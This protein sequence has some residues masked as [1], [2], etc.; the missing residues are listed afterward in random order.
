VSEVTETEAEK[1]IRDTFDQ[2]R[3]WHRTRLFEPNLGAQLSE[4]DEQWPAMAMSQMAKA[5]LDTAAE[6]LYTVQVLIE[7]GQLMPTALRTILRTAVVGS[8]QAVG[9][10]APDEVGDRMKRHRALMNETYTHHLKYLDGYW[11]SPMNWE[12]HDANTVEVRD[13][14]RCRGDQI[15]TLR[16]LAGERVWWNE[17]DVIH[18]AA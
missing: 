18:T 13:H 5:G 2:V 6:H 8:A 10:L 14:V 3:M 16:T 4:D 15:G 12:P 11:I 9:L 1:G 7:A 17:T